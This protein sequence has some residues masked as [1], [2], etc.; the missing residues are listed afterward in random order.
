[1]QDAAKGI[2]DRLGD[3]NYRMTFGEEGAKIDFAVSLSLARQ[4]RN[5]TQQELADLLGVSQAYIARLESGKANPTLSKVGRIYAA[6]WL[7]PIDQPFPLLR[8]YGPYEAPRESA[9][10]EPDTKAVAKKTTRKAER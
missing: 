2:A 8:G 4:E 6:L 9:T 5:L 7:K 10:G 1:M 3:N